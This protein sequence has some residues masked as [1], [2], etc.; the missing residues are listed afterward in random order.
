MSHSTTVAVPLYHNSAFQPGLDALSLWLEDNSYS[1][2]A[3][4]RILAH[5][6]VDG[7]PSGSP[8]LD[9]EDEAGSH[10]R[11]R[12]RPGVTSRSILR[13]GTIRAF[14][15]TPTRSE[16]PPRP[17]Q[18][19]R[20]T[21]PSRATRS[22]SRPNSRISSA[23]TALSG[24]APQGDDAERFKPGDRHSADALAR[25]HRALYGRSEPFHA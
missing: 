6:A 9:A 12:G 16:K 21:A 25:I 11:L 24:G 20:P 17:L 15:S 13:A 7:T 1:Q 10:R 22:S 4:D 3:R 8:Y 23:R 19:P 2:H 14:S 18:S 5:A